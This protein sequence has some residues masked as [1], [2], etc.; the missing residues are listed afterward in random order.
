MGLVHRENN[1]DR[2]VLTDS[3]C[4]DLSREI[5]VGL[6]EDLLLLANFTGIVWDHW[7]ARRVLTREVLQE[8]VNV[9]RMAHLKPNAPIAAHVGVFLWAQA[10]SSEEADQRR[11]ARTSDSPGP[12]D[13]AN[14]SPLEP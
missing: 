1:D 14:H 6:L 3:Y 12:E 11:E 7:G 10:I 4:P 2:F 5:R 8:G 13:E 9:Y